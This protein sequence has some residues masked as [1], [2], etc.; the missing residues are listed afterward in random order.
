MAFAATAAL[1]AATLATA[2]AS[3]AAAATGYCGP[4]LQGSS[5]LAGGPVVY[6]PA[7]S[8]EELYGTSTDGEIYQAIWKPARFPNPFWSNW[9][10]LDDNDTTGTLV[11]GTPSAVY[12]PVNDCLDVFARGTNGHLYLKFWWPHHNWQNWQPLGT[13]T[14]TGSPAAIYDPIT[15]LMDVYVTNA[16]NDSVDEITGN[17]AVGW[18]TVNLGGTITGNPF[19]VYDQATN[20][21]HMEVYVRG[22]A[23]HLFQKWTADGTNWSPWNDLGGNITGSP[24]AIY[25]PGSGNLDVYATQVTQTADTLGQK[26]FTPGVGWGDWRDFGGSIINSPSPVYVGGD[27]P[28][29]VFAVG[30]GGPPFN[31][32]GNGISGTWTDLKVGGDMVGSPAGIDDPARNATNN[33][34]EAFFLDSGGNVFHVIHGG[35]AWTIDPVPTTTGSGETVTL[36]SL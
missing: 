6:N 28:V 27:G 5:G 10:S 3:M 18:K 35:G 2:P 26:A 21:N 23:G 1:A 12:D 24:A 32:S 29:N 4:T 30:A 8:Y 34:L 36:A 13:G 20:P 11:T 33:P 22:T 7:S 19:P 16:A 25:D 31:N 14:I 9:I 17:Q 15:G